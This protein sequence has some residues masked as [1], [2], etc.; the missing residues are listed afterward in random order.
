MNPVSGQAD[1]LQSAACCA[2]LI[3]GAGAPL[4]EFSF[5]V[6][7]MDWRVDWLTIHDMHLMK[8]CVSALLAIVRE[9]FAKQGL[10]FFKF[11]YCTFKDFNTWILSK[12]WNEMIERPV[13]STWQATL[14][15]N[16][17]V[18]TF[19]LSRKAVDIQVE[20]VMK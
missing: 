13:I 16:S 6:K 19:L 2:L 9:I 8:F 7:E 14:T 15:F 3:S 17:K 1:C 10:F 20:Y 5:Q 4:G 12:C 11:H 18:C